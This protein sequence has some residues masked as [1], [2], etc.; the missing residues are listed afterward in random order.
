[1]TV[2]MTARFNTQPLEDLIGFYESYQQIA[3]E[4]MDAALDVI[5][6]DALSELGHEPGPVKHP[7]EWESDKQR[8]AF[9]A[10]DGFGRGIGA[11]RTHDLSQSWGIVKSMFGNDIVVRFDN[12]QPYA[13]FVYGSLSKTNPG[14][15]QQRM[16]K[17][18][19]WQSAYETV[20]FWV[21]ALIEQF[22]AN[23]RARL[24]ELT[25]NVTVRT[26]AYTGR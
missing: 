8:K 26:R 18:T 16:H 12:P 13:A 22:V 10:T 23:M 5:V 17:N 15:Y 6:P 24:G 25:G 19:G 9:F 1:M 7:V 14:D 21:A 2:R 3:S 20:D 11:E 4:E